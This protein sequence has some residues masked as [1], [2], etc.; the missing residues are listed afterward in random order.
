VERQIAGKINTAICFPIKH[1]QELKMV[2]KDR[3][4]LESRHRKQLEELE[5]RY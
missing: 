5:S 1:H 4:K 2:A 3:K